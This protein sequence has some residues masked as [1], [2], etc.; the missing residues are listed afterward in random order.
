[1]QV[2]QDMQVSLGGSPP[3]GRLEGCSDRWE[4][5]PASVLTIETRPPGSS[6]RWRANSPHQHSTRLKAECR[7][8][9]PGDP[10]PT[11]ALLRLFLVHQVKVV[12]ALQRPRWTEAGLRARRKGEPGKA[13]LARELR[14]KT[15]MPS[16]WIAARLNM[17]TR[18]HWAWLLQQR[19]SSRR[20]ALADQW[21]LYQTC[22]WSA[23]GLHLA[24]TW[25]VPGFRVAW[26]VALGSFGV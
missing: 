26:G 22:M 4:F 18:G 9:K 6:R 8:Q 25:S 5:E 19:A 21:P 17:G 13:Q 10:S 2:H 12:E 1:M 7:L 23:P 24:S 3:A 14:S 15:T 16:D 20:A 11:V